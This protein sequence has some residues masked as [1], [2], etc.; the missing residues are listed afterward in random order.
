MLSLD[1]YKLVH[2]F[3]IFMVLVSLGG[4][5]LHALD[6]GTRA[7]NPARRLVSITFG[8]GLF[9]VLLGG[10][11]QMARL[12]IGSPGTWGGW[13]YAKLGIWLFIGGLFTVPYRRPERARVLWIGVP[14]LG[15]IAGW[16]ALYKPF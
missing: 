3:G 13:I 16:L 11:G 10:F 1:V 4:V 15:L 8:I 12:G 6:G 14:V 2:L 9:L 7:A 5:I